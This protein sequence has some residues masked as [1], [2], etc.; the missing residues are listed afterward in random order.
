MPKHTAIELRESFDKLPT[1]VKEAITSTHV[2]DVIKRIS[3]KY[4]LR[5]DQGAVLEDEI[6]YVMYGLERPENFLSN[7]KREGKIEDSKA[8]AIAGEV[9]KD[10]FQAIRKELM[11]IHSPTYTPP[12][13]PDADL[14]FEE[15][16]KRMYQYAE[17]AGDQEQMMKIKKNLKSD[18]GPEDDIMDLIQNAQRKIEPETIETGNTVDLRN[19][20]RPSDGSEREVIEPKASDAKELS[21]KTGIP[22]QD[23]PE[24]PLAKPST[25]I[26]IDL[27]EDIEETTDPI[28]IATPKKET[29]G[30][31]VIPIKKDHKEKLNE[32]VSIPLRPKP[33]TSSEPESIMDK[34]MKGP[35]ITND[36]D[37]SQP[38]NKKAVS[39]NQSDSMYD[40][41]DPYREPVE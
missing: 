28:N 26:D 1:K 13:N 34:M 36:E 19:K 4:N 20:K 37:F 18:A 7:L 33:E 16:I 29:A 22:L 35:T 23:T 12:E 14:Q 25:E 2:D 38:I 32:D 24:I 40:T 41:P 31:D 39:P 5:I 15:L 27:D 17:E 6:T 8:S 21:E 10:I 30:P 9:E 3:Q 11:D